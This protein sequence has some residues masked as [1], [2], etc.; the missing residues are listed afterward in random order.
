MTYGALKTALFFLAT[1]LAGAVPARRLGVAT[2]L[3][4]RLVPTHQV[5]NARHPLRL[6]KTRCDRR[7]AA[8]L[9]V[10][11]DRRRSIQLVESVGQG[12]Q[13][14]VDGVGKMTLAPLFR[15]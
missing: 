12:S 1:A 10:E 7:S 14:N 3:H 9:A 8:A 2:A 11:N 13:R 15:A 6:K 5:G 4:P